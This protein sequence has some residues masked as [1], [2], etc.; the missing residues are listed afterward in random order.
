[1]TFKKEYE[2]IKNQL[3]Q[4]ATE[5]NVRTTKSAKLKTERKNVKYIKQSKDECMKIEHEY[6]QSLRKLFLAKVLM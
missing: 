4:I 5:I 6:E 2:D 3:D 1:M